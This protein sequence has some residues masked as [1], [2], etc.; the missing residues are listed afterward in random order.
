MIAVTRVGSLRERSEHG[1][2]DARRPNPFS[3]AADS[4]DVADV[5]ASNQFFDYRVQRTARMVR[6]TIRRHM[7]FPPG[8]PRPIRLATDRSLGLLEN[9][10]ERCSS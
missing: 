2:D 1:I 9:I 3:R 8:R 7:A 5:P 4:R 6:K 10:E